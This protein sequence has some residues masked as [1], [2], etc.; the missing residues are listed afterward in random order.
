[1][2]GSFRFSL[3]PLLDKR[4]RVEDARRADVAAARRVRDEHVAQF[5]RLRVLLR[6]RRPA[7]HEIEL[8]HVALDARAAAIARANAAL[9]RAIAEL[10]AA[11][12]ERRVLEKLRERRHAEYVR[13]REHG[14]ELE[15]EDANAT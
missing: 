11:R 7:P 5:E 4:A 8:F 14:E 9:L 6:A 2:G 10:A 3:A 1:M 13:A 15:I 12:R